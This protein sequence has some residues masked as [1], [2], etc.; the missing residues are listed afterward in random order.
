MLKRFI[1]CA[2]IL[3]TLLPGPAFAQ[4]L[5]ARA[6]L[7]ISKTAYTQRSM[8]IYLLVRFILQG[9]NVSEYHLRKENWLTALQN[10]KKDMII[11]TESE[12]LRQLRLSESEQTEL[13]GKVNT[14]LQAKAIQGYVIVLGITQADIRNAVNKFVLTDILIKNAEQSFRSNSKNKGTAFNFEEWE[15]QLERSYF[16][17]FFSEAEIFKPITPN[18]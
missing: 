7:E 6:I 4:I 8:E 12:R 13:L 5:G 17:R 10:F 18:L 1:L 15:T 16:I 3:M 11:A 9:G 2:S 14:A